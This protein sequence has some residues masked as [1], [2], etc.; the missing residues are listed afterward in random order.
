[1]KKREKIFYT[2]LISYIIIGIIPLILSLI[3]YHMCAKMIEG[4]IQVSQE[5]VLSQFGETF[6]HKI[7]NIIADGQLLGGNEILRNL[8]GKTTFSAD[9]RLDM[10]KLHDELALQKRG[11][12]LC[13]EIMVYFCKT[14]TILTDQKVYD[15]RLMQIYLRDGIH[16]EAS[17]EKVKQFQGLRG[18]VLGEDVQGKPLILFIENVYNY[19]YKTKLA[20]I[21]LAMPWDTLKNSFN[22]LKGG[23]LYWLNSKDESLFISGQNTGMVLPYDAFQTERELIYTGRGDDRM[24]SSFC[25]SQYSD[26]KYCVTMPEKYY[27]ESLGRLRMIIFIQMVILVVLAIIMSYYY[28]YQNYK[29]IARMIDTVRRSRNSKRNDVMVADLAEYMEELHVENQKLNTSWKKA[30]DSVAKQ[31]IAGYLKGWNTDTALLNET[32]DMISEVQLE[33][34]YMAFLIALGDISEC[35]LFYETDE[36][37]DPKMRELLQFI[38]CNIFEELILLKYKGLL[39]T[40]DDMY[41]CVLQ[42]HSQTEMDQVIDALKS[43]A[44]EYLALMNLRV[45][46]GGSSLHRGIE[47]LPKAYNE[48]LQV[49]S[50]QSFWGATSEF[51]VIYENNYNVQ[52]AWSE[53]GYVLDAQRKLYNFLLCQEYESARDLLNDIMDH[54]FIREISYT[55]VNQCRMLGLVNTVCMYLTDIIGKRDEQFLQELHP[56][57]RLLKAKSV[58]EAKAG[59]QSIF[60]EIIAHLKTYLEE[61]RPK[62]VEDMVDM[63]ETNYSDV[64]LNV[65]ALAE[66][67]D[68]NLA[69]VGRTFKQYMGVSL[70]D[71]IHTVR[72]RECKKLLA[73]GVSVKAAAEKVGY[74]DSKSLIRIFKKQEGITPGQY[75]NTPEL[76]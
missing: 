34:E 38:F 62:W 50:Y 8:A 35:K 46:M 63:V 74:V 68:M 18:Y 20:V 44:E 11:L 3:G 21:V 33:E 16:S 31:V 1:M 56:M 71:Y 76:E 23:S 58:E 37:N 9:D 41:F 40:V 54:M 60:N 26:W 7:E 49:L 17:L 19:N 64:N 67:V 27:F 70:P 43:C 28:S 66:K 13:S 22:N 73:Q 6:D 47:N 55:E 61:E 10:K 24:I 42:L 52:T 75:R 32:L 39:V 69:Y 25:S 57:E 59:I 12:D 36:V 48:T 51:L 15:E 53:E 72:I 30:K 5:S 14:D 29:P 4:E 45:F 2:Y 65:S